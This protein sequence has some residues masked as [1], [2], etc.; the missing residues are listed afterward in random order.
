MPKNK[1]RIYSSKQ[2][3]DEKQKNRKDV[4][5]HKKPL[6]FFLFT[7]Q[8]LL[9]INAFEVFVSHFIGVAYWLRWLSIGR[10][11]NQHFKRATARKSVLGVLPSQDTHKSIY[12][13]AHIWDHLGQLTLIYICFY[14]YWT[15]IIWYPLDLLDGRY[16]T[17]NS[18]PCIRRATREW[19]FYVRC[20]LASVS[21]IP[22]HLISHNMIG[23]WMCQME[24]KFK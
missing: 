7:F 10:I 22:P 12:V 17:A 5:N 6:L 16:F 9:M 18:S 15:W 13:R 11:A 20:R 3:T 24:N 23:V 8:L 19:H 14:W 2:K 21:F 4:A 1:K